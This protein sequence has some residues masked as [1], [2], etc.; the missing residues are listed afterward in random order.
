MQDVFWV[1][2][3]V[4]EDDIHGGVAYAIIQCAVVFLWRSTQSMLA[5]P[6]VT[7]GDPNSESILI[8]QKTRYLTYS[9]FF[10]D[11]PPET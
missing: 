4:V 10:V 8:R 9:I 5:W 11:L 6:N 2:L 7:E 3:M 1:A